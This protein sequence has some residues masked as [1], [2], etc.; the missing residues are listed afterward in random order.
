MTKQEQERYGQNQP[1]EHEPLAAPGDSLQVV[2][3][4]QP[5][6]LTSR[7]ANDG[8]GGLD[9]VIG[10]GLGDLARV[11]LLVVLFRVVLRVG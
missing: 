6:W 4:A 9:L 3:V 11:E 8:A 10:L 2:E 7:S 5:A 1:G